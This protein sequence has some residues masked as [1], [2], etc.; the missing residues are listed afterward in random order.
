MAAADSEPGDVGDDDVAGSFLDCLPPL[1]GAES[2]NRLR[3]VLTRPAT[4]RNVG[5]T[6]LVAVDDVESGERGAA[7][8]AGSASCAASCAGA[9]TDTGADSSGASLM[10]VPVLLL[11]SS[12]LLL[13]LL[14]PLSAMPLP[15]VGACACDG[16]GAASASA[17]A[18]AASAA[19]PGMAS[20]REAGKASKGNATSY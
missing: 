8:A 9:C 16:D 11:P 13:V 10:V 15:S 3:G 4:E 20:K 7:A 2:T 5:D 18:S 19:A 14:L 6:G 17:P 1:L 12:L